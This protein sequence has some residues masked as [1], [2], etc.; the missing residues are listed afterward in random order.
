MC[1]FSL[2]TQEHLF[3]ILHKIL[4]EF[5]CSDKRYSTRRSFRCLSRRGAEPTSGRRKPVTATKTRR[6]SPST[7]P[8]AVTLHA[9]PP[10][11]HRGCKIVVPF[12]EEQQA[13]TPSNAASVSSPLL[14]PTLVTVATYS[15]SPEP[16]LRQSGHHSQSLITLPEKLLQNT[17]KIS[18][19]N[20]MD[21][22]E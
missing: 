10:R 16:H 12:Q 5:A 22:Q 11:S 13:S 3:R 14:P 7:C 8:A 21:H 15:S 4:N 9:G 17:A 1:I 18:S 2:G 19:H 20:F 6:T